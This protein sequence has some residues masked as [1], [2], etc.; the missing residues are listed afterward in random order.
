M[1]LS[2]LTRIKLCKIPSAVGA[3]RTE[4]CTA[5]D[6]MGMDPGERESLLC[7]TEELGGPD[8]MAQALSGEDESGMVALFAASAECGLQMIGA[9][10]GGG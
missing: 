2:S 7:I 6:T 4:F 1:P 10:G 9:P 3:T 8:G 5:S